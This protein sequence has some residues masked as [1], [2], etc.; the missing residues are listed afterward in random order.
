[1]PQTHV[2]QKLT[3]ENV[4]TGKLYERDITLWLEGVYGLAK[5]KI[6]QSPDVSL[7]RFKDLFSIFILL[8]TELHH[9]ACIMQLYC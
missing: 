2:K 6:V 1:M 8:L 5:V 4:Q 3:L 7:G 9:C